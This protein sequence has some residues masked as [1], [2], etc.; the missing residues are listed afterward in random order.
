MLESGE[1]A[2]VNVFH[3]YASWYLPIFSFQVSA[4]LNR[5]HAAGCSLGPALLVT[6]WII[7]QLLAGWHPMQASNPT[8]LYD[9]VFP[10]L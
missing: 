9:H 5:L 3:L 10:A 6:T 7:D 1:P 4:E 2:E 8:Y